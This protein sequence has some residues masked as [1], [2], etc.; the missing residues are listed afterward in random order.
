M[1]EAVAGKIDLVEA[2]PY[3]VPLDAIDVSQPALY[4]HD[5]FW[6]Y[7][8]RLRREDPVHYCPD[9]Q[10]GPFWSITKFN[11]IV[12]VE[13]HHEIFSSAAGIILADRPE[14]FETVNFIGMDP[15][16]HDEQRKAVQGVV[17]PR[18]LAQMEGLIRKRAG[19]ILDSLPTGETFNW[20]DLVSIELTTQMLA[21]LFD[22]PFEDRRKL[23]HWS[24][25]ATSGELA[26]GPTPEP[27]RRAALMECLDVM[28]RLRDERIGHDGF[29]L[30]TML[31]NDDSTR[32]MPP[33]EFLGNLILLIVGGNDT[34]RNSIS[35]G[36][37]A[38]N[39]NPA[40]YDKLMAD[41]SLIPNM[42]S[43]IIRWQTPLA[44]MRRTA[45][46]DTELRGKQIRKGDKVAMWYVS[47]NRDE[48][49]ID[50]PDDFIIERPNARHHVSFGF[51]IHRCMGNR[52]A[53][54]QLRLVWEE[55]VKRFE[56]VEV[57]GE[58]VRVQSSF[59]KGYAELPVR[60]HPRA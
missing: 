5:R 2:D 45:T 7:F 32:H 9:S 44:Y 52:L 13:Q 50:R 20:V 10:F 23:T 54:M 22:F 60:L 25:M 47:G 26:G 41:T 55:I 46:Q 37:L 14:D 53:E 19:D 48:E 24:D 27:V 36:V 57:V 28:T 11:D 12:Y 30:L 43:E 49:V 16:K 17:A 18:N 29:D 42:V 4:E 58:P 1:A 34:T 31:A 56:R 3:S 15:P 38:L 39:Q 6:P 40:E 59:V 51:G 21:T 35:G 8:E 33:M